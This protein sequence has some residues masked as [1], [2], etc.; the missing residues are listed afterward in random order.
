MMTDL[1]S[2]L[3]RALREGDAADRRRSITKRNPLFRTSSTQRA[4]PGIESGPCIVCAKPELGH[5][6]WCYGCG[7]FV[8][9]THDT[10]AC[11]PASSAHLPS[12]HARGFC[13]A[14]AFS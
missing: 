6:S 4:E 13:D 14:R 7:S 5:G 11:L 9:T 12:D 1:E 8:C 3:A 2:R 10:E